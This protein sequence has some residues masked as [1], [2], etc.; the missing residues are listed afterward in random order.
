MVLVK[1]C[2]KDKYGSV[3]NQKG[4]SRT[5]VLKIIWKIV[6]DTLLGPVPPHSFEDHTAAVLAVYF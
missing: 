3:R 2:F 4:I 1:L 6:Q 5:T